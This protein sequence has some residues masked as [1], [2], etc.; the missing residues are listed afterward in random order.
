MKWNPRATQALARPFL[1]RGQVARWVAEGSSSW[2][3]QD[4]YL[5]LTLSTTV[6]GLSALEH[7]SICC[8][9][10]TEFQWSLQSE[11]TLYASITLSCIVTVKSGQNPQLVILHCSNLSAVL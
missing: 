4:L 1:S 8:P 10:S 5:L 9:P 11:C 6:Q 2:L 3:A 7:H